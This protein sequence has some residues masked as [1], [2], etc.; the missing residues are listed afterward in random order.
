MAAIAMPI[1]KHMIKCDAGT[2]STELQQTR[3]L[4]PS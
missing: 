1:V 3:L 2:Q 4:F